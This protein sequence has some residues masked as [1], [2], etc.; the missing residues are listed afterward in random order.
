MKKWYQ[1]KTV[2][3]G[4]LFVITAIAGLFGFQ[5]YQPSPDVLKIVELVTGIIIVVLRLI[6]KNGVEKSVV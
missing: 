6:T 3:F 1:S 5:T 4:L 2:Y